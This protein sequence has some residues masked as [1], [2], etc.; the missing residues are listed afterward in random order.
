VFAK[1]QEVIDLDFE[2]A[3]KEVARRVMF[4]GTDLFRNWNYAAAD[5]NEYQQWLE[6]IDRFIA[7]KGRSE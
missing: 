7:T 5:S 4:E 2:F 3:D 1:V 6:K